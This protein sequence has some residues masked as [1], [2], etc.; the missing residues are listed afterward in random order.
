MRQD[1]E[2]DAEPVGDEAEDHGG[3]DGGDW[4][5]GVVDSEGYGEAAEAGENSFD[6]D[7]LFAGFCGEPVGAVVFYAPAHASAEDE[8]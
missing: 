1:V 2:V 7:D 3:Q 6:H 4:G 8:E 5:D